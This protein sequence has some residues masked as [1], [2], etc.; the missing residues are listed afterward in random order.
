ME[1]PV[2]EKAAETN[3]VNLIRIGC[4]MTNQ[5]RKDWGAAAAICA[6]LVERLKGDV[7]CWWH[8]DTLTRSWS[9]EALIAD[10]EL[11]EYV[12]ITQPPVDD[13]WLASQYQRCDLTI[14]PSSEGFG[15][16]I[17]E[18]F[19][20][21]VPCLHGDYAGGASLMR[22]FGLH[23][24]LIAPREWRLDGQHNCV[25][26]VFSPNDW[27]DKIMQ[28]LKQPPDVQWLA[29]RVEHLSYMKLGHVFRRWFKDGIVHVK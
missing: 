15:Y 10:F 2:V 17:F 24:Y 1:S 19:A 18:S 20:C 25:R 3:Q 14:L 4:V 21:G 13:K 28:V 12:E 22:A 23:D 7:K 9:I 27:V 8:V 26:P 29:S 5:N 6:G 16:P 11:G